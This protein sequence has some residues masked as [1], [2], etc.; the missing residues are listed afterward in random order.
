[1]ANPEGK[2]KPLEYKLGPEADIGLRCC[3]D[4]RGEKNECWASN[5]GGDGGDGGDRWSGLVCGR[6]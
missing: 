3:S 4:R 5:L 1:M 6:W 2:E